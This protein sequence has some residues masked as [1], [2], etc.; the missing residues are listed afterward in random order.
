[1]HVPDMFW[2]I[3]LISTVLYSMAMSTYAVVK[4]DPEKDSVHSDLVGNLNGDIVTISKYLTV[5]PDAV[6]TGLS[7]ADLGSSLTSIK[8]INIPSDSLL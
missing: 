8:N 2:L 3:L 7:G 5:G 1:M 6:V 4:D